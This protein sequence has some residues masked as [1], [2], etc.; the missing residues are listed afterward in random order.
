MPFISA[1]DQEKLRTR[2]EAELE[3]E[4]RVVLFAEP[5]TAL[6]V[7]G[8]EQSQ[9]GK[10][11][12]QLLGELA[13]LSPL[14]KLEVHNPRVERELAESF[15]VERSPAIV[16]L[17]ADPANTA[18]AAS[19]T[20]GEATPPRRGGAV[21]FFGLPSGYEFTTLIEDLVDL[22]KGSTRLSEVTRKAAAELTEPVHLQVFVT[23]T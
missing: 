21:R 5:P 4:V 20:N 12:T 14:L 3:R 1:P 8:R 15:G 10:A 23:P 19:A 2:F 16:L 18:D 22:S 13:A 17:P 11:A 6:Y 9:T 7:P